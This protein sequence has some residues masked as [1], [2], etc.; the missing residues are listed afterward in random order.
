MDEAFQP[1]FIDV[2]WTHGFETEPIRLVSQLDNERYEIRK[3][4]FFRDGRVRI[5]R[6]PQFGN[7]N[8]AWKAAG[9]TIG[10]DE[11]GCTVQRS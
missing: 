9:P 3:L 1:I 7:G 8:S 5:R 10:R 2:A 4:E 6:R 11:F